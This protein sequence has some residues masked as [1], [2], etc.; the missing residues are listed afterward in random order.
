M[1]GFVAQGSPDLILKTLADRYEQECMEGTHDGVGE[2][3]LLFGGGPGDWKSK[4]LNYLARTPELR[5]GDSA[6]PMLKRAIGAHY[7]QVPMLGELG[8][9]STTKSKLGHSHLDQ[10]LVCSGP[11]L[12]IHQVTLPQ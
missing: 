10:S 8:W 11:R 6:K 12:H 3:T 4:G 5:N 9:L 1:S 7:G 2:L